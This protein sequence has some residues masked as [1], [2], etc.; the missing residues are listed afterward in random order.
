MADVEV[1]DPADYA[2][3]TP[4]QKER[5]H[6]RLKTLQLRLRGLTE[7]QIANALQVSVTTVS[8]DLAYVYR[9]WKDKYGLHPTVDP[10]VI[11]G[12]AMTLYQETERMALVEY[13][14]LSNG[15]T[16]AIIARSKMACLKMAN[17][18]KDRQVNLLQDLGILHRALGTV[19]VNLPQASEIRRLLK[20]ATVTEDMLLPPAQQDEA[21]E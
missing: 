17:E 10:A 7:P 6:R 1:L 8:M 11:V 13:N 4:S 19:N 2:D 16:N 18:A 9:E 20:D 3:L 14:K 15:P 12:E 21:T 5:Q